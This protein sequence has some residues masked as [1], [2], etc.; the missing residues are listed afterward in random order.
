M[1]TRAERIVDKRTSCIERQLHDACDAKVV[2][3]IINISI[4][5]DTPRFSARVYS[6]GKIS[7]IVGPQ[8]IG[9]K[10]DGRGEYWPSPCRSVQYDTVKSVTVIRARSEMLSRLSWRLY[11][12]YLAYARMYR[13][14]QMRLYRLWTQKG[15]SNA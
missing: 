10:D 3:R 6:C 11:D 13:K 4:L 12:K 1:E 2:V 9:L 15:S 5:N 14:V 7:F 8:G